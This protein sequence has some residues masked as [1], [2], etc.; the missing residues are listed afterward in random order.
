M[1][2]ATR[3]IERIARDSV[4]EALRRSLDEIVARAAVAHP[5]GRSDAAVR[6]FLRAVQDWRPGGR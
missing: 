6:A 2:A 5:H 4:A 3:T 1:S